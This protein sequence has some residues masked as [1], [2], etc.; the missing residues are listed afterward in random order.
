[1][2]TIEIDT[3]GFEKSLN[4]LIKGLTQRKPLMQ[5]LAM[6]MLF[7][8]EK[9]FQQQGRPAWAGWSPRYAREASRR[10][11]TNILQCSGRL[12]ASITPASD[13]DTARVGTN[14]KY[15]AIHQ[16]GGNIHIAARSQQAYYRQYKNGSVGSRFV[17][18]GRSNYSEWHT[19]PE[20]NITM[21]ARPFLS[22]EDSDNAAMEDSVQRYLRGLTG[23]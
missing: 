7:A 5:T 23:G 11:Q 2:Y 20:Y 6:H 1:M 10:G 8:V 12:A 14:V 18:K 19:L 15:A 4:R 16:E 22:L 3:T 9:N 21:P 17:R 13:N